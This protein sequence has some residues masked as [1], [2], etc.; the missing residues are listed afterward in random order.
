MGIVDSL[1]IF[2]TKAKLGRVWLGKEQYCL[3]LGKK[4][5]CVWLGKEQ[6]CL[7]LGKDYKE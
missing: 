2:D 1:I 4:Q 3:W 6:Y 7:W 5:Y